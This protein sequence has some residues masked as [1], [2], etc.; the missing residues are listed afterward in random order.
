MTQT[1]S[2]SPTPSLT[3]DVQGGRH[4]E[5]LPEAALVEVADEAVPGSDDR[6]DL[7][8][9]RLQSLAKKLF[10]IVLYCAGRFLQRV[11]SMP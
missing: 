6:V 7:R 8:G 5:P 9:P 10:S 4:V 2:S 1:R 11:R 3:H